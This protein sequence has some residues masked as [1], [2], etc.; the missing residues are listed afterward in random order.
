ME[1]HDRITCL[2]ALAAFAWA[3][4]TVSEAE[5]ARIQEFICGASDIAAAEIARMI[6][7][8]RGLSSELLGKITA[9]PAEH[10]CEL[11]TVADTMCTAVRPATAAETVLLRQ[12]AVARFGEKNWPRIAGWLEHQRQAN[13]FLDGLLDE[14]V[15]V[16]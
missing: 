15:V 6:G 7:S 8:V 13:N 5:Q 16:S 2:E 4:G 14:Y 10:V 3:D 9:M 1:P 11:L 12:I